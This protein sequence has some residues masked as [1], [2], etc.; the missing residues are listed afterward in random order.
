MKSG[1]SKRRAG[2]TLMELLI[3]MSLLSLLSLGVVLAMRVGLGAMDKA[4]KRLQANRRAVGAQKALEQQ[5]AGFMPVVADC[6]GGTE[7]SMRIQFFQG[8]PESMRFVSAYSLEEGGR[9]RPRILEFQ[10]IPGEEKRGVRLVVNERLYSGPLSTGATCGG[11][12]QD[13]VSGMQMVQFL[14]IEIGPQSFVLADKLA[15]C[16]FSYR[17]QVAPPE[18]ER[19]QAKWIRPQWPTAV[20][21]D[22]AP[23]DGEASQL[24]PVAITA[25]IRVTKSAYVVYQDVR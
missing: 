19:W 20:R 21:I 2:V 22:M 13:P 18:F 12:V 8:E 23:L 14:P 5:L 15:R 25:P 24:P 10:V 4:N 3:A 11:P 16:Q 7:R 9:G 6:M 17:E 1:A